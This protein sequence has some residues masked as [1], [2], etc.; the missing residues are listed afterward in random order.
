M[1][2]HNDL[3]FVAIAAISCFKKADFLLICNCI[4]IIFVGKI[5]IKIR[6]TNKQGLFTEVE[7]F[8]N[9][10]QTSMDGIEIM[11]QKF[12]ELKLARES[13]DSTK[14]VGKLVTDYILLYMLFHY[15]WEHIFL[16]YYS[17]HCHTVTDPHMDPVTITV[18]VAVTVK[19]VHISKAFDKAWHAGLLHKLKASWFCC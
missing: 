18:S 19:D 17:D 6:I 5:L 15:N 8:I 10:T 7:T 12:Q 9:V 14:A 16:F 4:P 1:L 3:N 2:D 13:G 11:D